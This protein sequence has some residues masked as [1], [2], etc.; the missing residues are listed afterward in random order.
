MD[1]GKINVCKRKDDITVIN[2]LWESYVFFGYR[3]RNDQVKSDLWSWGITQQWW[4]RQ[5]WSFW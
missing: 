3:Y 5:V 4:E 2:L 1:T